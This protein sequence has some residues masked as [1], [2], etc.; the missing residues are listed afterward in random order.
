[1]ARLEPVVLY[2]V[3]SRIVAILSKK[4]QIA[5]KIAAWRLAENP[6]ILLC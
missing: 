2:G 4:A 1:M 5:D 3:R 6:K